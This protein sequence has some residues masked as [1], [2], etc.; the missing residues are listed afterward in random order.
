MR[1]T[2]TINTSDYEVSTT[3][4]QTPS[5]TT[6]VGTLYASITKPTFDINDLTMDQKSIEQTYD[7]RIRR[8]S[9]TVDSSHFIEWDSV[10]YSIVGISDQQTAKRYV[11]MTGR[12]LSE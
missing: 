2:I 3:G 8:P 11:I 6:V 5:G 12:C 9:F 7:F 1:D 4:Q 10:Q